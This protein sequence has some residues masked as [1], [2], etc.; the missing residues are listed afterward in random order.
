[1]TLHSV[2]DARNSLSRLIERSRAGEEVIITNRG[3]PVAQLV[4]IGPV[5]APLTGAALVEWIAADPIPERLART[6]TEL[7]AQIA[8]ARGAWE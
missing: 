7:D 8:D 6:A 2:F 5:D 3:R 4:P 1:M